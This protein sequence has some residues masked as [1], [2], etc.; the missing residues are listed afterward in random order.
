MSTTT[1][2]ES[3][4][5]RAFSP[6]SPGLVAVLND[7]RDFELAES[8]H[9]YRIPV[10][11]A[12]D[13]LCDT[14]WIAFYLTKAFGREKWCVR[15]WANVR[16]ITQAARADL[17]PDEKRHPRARNLYYCLELDELQVRPEPIFSRR[18]RRIVFIP[19]IWRKFTT[20]LEINDLVHGSPLED[21][22][23]A[24]FKQE[25]IEAERQWWEWDKTT[26]YCLDFA[27]FCPERN[28]DVECD[29]DTWHANPEA[30][31]HDNAR[32]N[33]LEG[34]GWHVLRFNTRQLTDDLAGCV[35][36]VTTLINRCGGLLRSD[37]TV[38]PFPETRADG[39]KQ[40]R[41]F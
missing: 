2:A 10:Q 22:L 11:S 36:N 40:G 27:L 26:R 20:A 31:V 39:W 29:G 38:K 37:D 6:E 34:R 13:G 15:H 5:G 23:W 24:A 35:R 18:R 7:R 41:L 1:A 25:E 8:E 19:S 4:R 33:F 9:W 14:R 16:S 17:L 32:N 21:R 28:I 3:P 30:A 12:P